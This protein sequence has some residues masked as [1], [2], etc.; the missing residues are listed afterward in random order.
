MN[1]RRRRRHTPE[2]IVKKL[3]DAEF[4]GRQIDN[5]NRVGIQDARYP[6]LA[7]DSGE[8]DHRI[9]RHITRRKW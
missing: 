1:Q 7:N 3:R 9:Q 8:V 4:S 6:P 2:Q 5:I